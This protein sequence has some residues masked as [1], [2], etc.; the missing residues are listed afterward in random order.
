MARRTSTP[1][2]TLGWRRRRA[3]KASRK[4]PT[5]SRRSPRLRSRTRDG[6]P[7]AN[8]PVSRHPSEHR[9]N[10]GG[11]SRPPAVSNGAER[12]SRVAEPSPDLSREVTGEGSEWKGN[13]LHEIDG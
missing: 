5:G 3:K 8:H 4:S 2:C 7:R 9:S 10:G 11:L 12:L 1:T 6:S 13:R